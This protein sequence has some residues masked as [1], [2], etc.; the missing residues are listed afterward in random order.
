MP[1]G[2]SFDNL[3][4]FLDARAEVHKFEKVLGTYGIRIKP[5]SDLELVAIIISE[6]EDIRCGRTVVDAN[7]DPRPTFRKAIGLLEFV[8]MLNRQHAVS[9]LASFVGHLQLLNKAASVAPG[10]RTLR[11][12]A[13][14]KL[15]EL[16]WAMI[17][18][19]VGAD[20]KLD[21]P[22]GAKGDNPDVLVTIDGRRWGFACKAIEGQNPLSWYEL[23]K[24]GLEQIDKSPEA[25]TGCVVFNPSTLV[26]HDV[27]WP[28]LNPEFQR[29]EE[30]P[31]LGW[32]I[33]ED[34]VIAL[35]RQTVTNLNLRLIRKNHQ[36][37]IE[38]LFRDGQRKSIPLTL[39][40]MQTVCQIAIGDRWPVSTVAFL[41]GSFIDRI[42]EKD[43]G[44]LERL[45]HSLQTRL[46]RDPSVP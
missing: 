27:M 43:Q 22:N 14:N 4:P 7:Q 11:D 16:F 46:R 44:V 13:S 29:Q 36:E 23:L 20:L 32:W 6:L 19:A 41:A 35:L 3:I 8:A 18:L 1:E 38:K 15:F 26:N 42:S 45:N 40:V 39:S 25:E 24:K 30:P 28:L 37:E 17:C 31:V 2:N 21:P 9:G 5:G 33:H 10:V 34:A 12:E